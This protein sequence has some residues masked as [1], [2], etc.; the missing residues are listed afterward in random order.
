[1]IHVLKLSSRNLVILKHG[2][3]SSNGLTSDG[4]QFINLCVMY[5]Y[6]LMVERES[7]I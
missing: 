6:R 2:A 7:N 4:M 1:M 5:Q 3:L